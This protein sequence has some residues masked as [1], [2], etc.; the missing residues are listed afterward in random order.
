MP[1][2]L[3]ANIFLGMYYNQSVWYKLT[4][5]TSFGAGLAIFGAVVT[6][7]LNVLLIPKYGYM[8]SAWSTFACY[9]SMMVASYFF[10]RKYYPVPYEIGKLAALLIGA[11]GLYYLSLAF[12]IPERWV[13]MMVNLLFLLGYL[14]I[15]WVVLRPKFK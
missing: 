13:G 12:T 15:S 10:G 7:V 6:V 5:R 14:G 1:I 8:A 11:F 2:L 3:M 4:D 9:G